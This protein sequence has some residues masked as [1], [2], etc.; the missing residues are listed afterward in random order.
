MACEQADVKCEDTR[1]G[2][3][4]ACTRQIPNHSFYTDHPCAPLTRHLHHISQYAS[5]MCS[6]LKSEALADWRLAG[7][8][9]N[10]NSRSLIH[11]SST[12]SRM[13][14]GGAPDS[15]LLRKL[16]DL[17]DSALDHA[18]RNSFTFSRRPTAYRVESR[19]PHKIKKMNKLKDRLFGC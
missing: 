12:F 7:V 16:R 13:V 18:T 4:H 17:F 2:M 6:R 9:F 8:I 15:T 10:I 11:I 1:V 14:L 19:A 3:H 5:R